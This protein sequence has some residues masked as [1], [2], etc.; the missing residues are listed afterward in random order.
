M[1]IGDET[2]VAA[3]GTGNVTIEPKFDHTHPLFV[4]P[5]EGSM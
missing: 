2:N 3:V 4:H 1:E 5:S